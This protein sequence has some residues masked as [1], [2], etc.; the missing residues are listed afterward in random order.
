MYHVKGTYAIQPVICN[1]GS[2]D[3]KETSRVY[4]LVLITVNKD[5]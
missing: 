3:V 5:L 2:L 4:V 1:D